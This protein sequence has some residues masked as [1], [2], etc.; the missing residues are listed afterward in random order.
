MART[1]YTEQKD[2]IILECLRRHP[3]NKQLGF[4][5][6]S[7][8]LGI[9]ANNL[10][11]RY[12][13]KLIRRVNDIAVASNSVIVLGKNTKRTDINRKPNSR[14]VR[15]SMLLGAYKM[16]SKEEAISHI[17][18]RLDDTQQTKLL[19]DIIGKIGG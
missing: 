2:S 12:Y 17:I 4:E 15:Q 16:M 11:Q 13:T 1:N 8:Q 3:D 9:P 14:L 19:R 7:K 10:Q 6:A 18:E 5:Q